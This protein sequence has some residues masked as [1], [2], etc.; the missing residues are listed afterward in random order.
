MNFMKRTI[1]GSAADRKTTRTQTMPKTVFFAT[2]AIV[3]APSAWAYEVVQSHVTIVE[4]SY[5]PT[6]VFFQVDTGSTSC[7]AG[8]WLRWANATVDGNKAVFSLLL[9]AVNSG[10][11]IQ[12][13][14][15]NGDTTCQVQFLYAIAP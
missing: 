8:T 14:V 9:A 10:N 4:S 12:Y 2:L 15:T 3:L 11:R 6:Q 5:M 1:Q 13:F 7:P